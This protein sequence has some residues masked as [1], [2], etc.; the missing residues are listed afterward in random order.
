VGLR[1]YRPR[2]S[3][4]FEHWH[5]VGVIMLRILRNSAVFLLIAALSACGSHRGSSASGGPVGIIYSF[6]KES[7]GT[8]PSKGSTLLLGFEPDGTAYLYA[9]KPGERMA[10]HGHWSYDGTRMTLSIPG[11]SVDTT[12][13]LSLSDESVTLPFQVFSDK[14]GTSQWKRLELP[15]LSGIFASYDAALADPKLKLGQEEAVKHA[16]KYAQERRPGGSKAKSAHRSM[17]FGTTASGWFGSLVPAARAAGNGAVAPPCKDGIPL[18]DPEEILGDYD[19]LVLFWNEPCTLRLELL[20][21]PPLEGEQQAPLD[22]GPLSGDP[23]V[24]IDPK[25]PGDSRFDPPSKTALIIAPFATESDDHFGSGVLY[26]GEPTAATWQDFRIVTALEKNGYSQHRELLNAQAGVAAIARAL[27]DDPKPGVLII[28]THGNASGSLLTRD[29]VSVNPGQDTDWHNANYQ[30]YLQKLRDEG[31]GDLVDF[32]RPTDLA[33]DAP[34]NPVTLHPQLHERSGPLDL[35]LRV[36][37][38]PL[39]WAWL[40]LDHGID[41]R[42]TL[43]L[44]MACSTDRTDTL[45]KFMQAGSYF[46]WSQLV[47]KDLTYVVAKYIVASLTRSTHSAEEAF[48][49]M[50][51]IAARRQMVYAEDNLLNYWL[52]TGGYDLNNLNAYG[53]DGQALLSYRENGWFGSTKITNGGHIWWLLFVERW[54]PVVSV[55]RTKMLEC[56]N[57]FWQGKEQ[58]GLKSPQCQNYQGGGAPNADE[59]GYATY[60]LDGKAEPSF[61][62][63]PV[64]RWTLNDGRPPD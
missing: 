12:S 11:L 22:R 9:Y 6:V 36:G 47:A 39:F 51:R 23:R 48:Y 28:F 43:V 55:G 53:W 14:P 4:F 24:F 44:M 30:A 5:G 46:T 29:S 49:N 20:L 37:L 26:G 31:F 60:L 61:S 64:P 25:S 3:G 27:I 7:G 10:H 38:T 52:G 15:Y 1:A 18:G 41:F 54:S 21:Q 56:W 16:L 63:T 58:P 62:G 59:L 32:N 57:L 13:A 34:W 19:Y 50:T 45:R 2:V 33:K 8:T 40:E 17:P 35:E 42:H